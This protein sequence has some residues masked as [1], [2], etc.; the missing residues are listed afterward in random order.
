M[1]LGKIL[2]LFRIEI[3]DIIICKDVLVHLNFIDALRTLT[4]IKNSKSTYFLST[5]FVDF[6]NININTG[7]WRPINLLSTPFNLNPPIM[8]YPNIEGFK[9]GWTNKGIGIWKIN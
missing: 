2:H 6:E 9:S 1:Y 3:F 5:T 7:Q 8:F 4:N